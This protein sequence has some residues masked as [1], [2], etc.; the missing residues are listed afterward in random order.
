MKILWL[1]NI[2]SPYRVDFFNEFGRK[3]ELTVIFEREGSIDRD[4]SWLKYKFNN[5]TGIILKGI[6]KTIRLNVIKYLK[7]DIYDFVVVSNPLTPTGIVAIKYMKVNKIP[8]SIVGDGGFPKDNNN[9]KE[10]LKKIILRGAELYF[11]TGEFHDKYYLKYGASSERIVRYPFTSLRQNDI[12]INPVDKLAKKKLKEKLGIKEEKVIISVG[13]YIH[14][15]GF[16]ILIKASNKLEGNIGIYIIGGTPTKDYIELI[17]KYNINNIHFEEF[18]SKEELS[19][20]YKA[21]DLFVL[22]TRSD[23]WGLVVNEA[24]AHGLPIIT[25]NRCGAGLELV[26]EDENGYIVPVDNIEDLAEKMNRIIGSD[27]LLEKMSSSSLEI[28][29]RYTIENMVKRHMEVFSKGK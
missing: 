11:S 20:Y 29:K 25:T 17:E 15:K 27:M 23:V 14:L 22:P 6:G 16:D 3:C 21:A 8:Y 10:Q 9:Y 1:T 26:N 24:M 28:I 4:K 18:K 13:R 12:L 7:K 5:F 2:P 19:L